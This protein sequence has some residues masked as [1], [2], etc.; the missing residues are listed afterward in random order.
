MATI[1]L[2]K[3]KFKAPIGIYS[4]E[5]LLKNDIEVNLLLHVHSLMHVKALK[6]TINYELI[7]ELIETEVMVKTDLLEDTLQR[8]VASVYRFC[9]KN[10]P[11]VVLESIDCKI[12]KIC[13]PIKGEIGSV[14]IQEHMNCLQLE[15]NTSV[16]ELEKN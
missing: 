7:F 6:E 4:A 5:K 2:E 12:K 16:K 14:W 13:P 9:T 1:A 8:I 3:L 10:Y 15:P 11:S